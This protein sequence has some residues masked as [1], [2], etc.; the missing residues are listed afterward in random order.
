M[1]HRLRTAITLIVLLAVVLGGAAW[2]WSRLTSP[3]AEEAGGPCT[4]TEVG[5]GDRVRT[6]QVVVTVLNAGDRSGLASRTMNDLTDRGFVPGQEANAP[7]GTRVSR[8]Q[9]WTDEPRSPAVMLVRD[10]LGGA[11][12]VRRDPVGVGVNVVVGDGFTRL[13]AGRRA[14]KVTADTTICLAGG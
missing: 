8:A 2:G 4:E 9:I 3:A 10:H 6:D 11:S 7:D 5:A 13:A 12:V 1:D 14:V